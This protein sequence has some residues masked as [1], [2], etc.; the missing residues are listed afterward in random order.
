MKRKNEM[1]LLLI[2]FTDASSGAIIGKAYVVAADYSAAIEAARIEFTRRKRLNPS[3]V[4]RMIVSEMQELSR[5]DI[6]DDPILII[7]KNN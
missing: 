1:N 2:T 3:V 4:S 7:I 5:E 6:Q